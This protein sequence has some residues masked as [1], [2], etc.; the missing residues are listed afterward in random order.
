VWV[1]SLPVRTRPSLQ[2]G[3]PTSELAVSPFDHPF[4]APLVGDAEVAA[5]LAPAAEIAA[6]VAFETALAEAE[7]RSG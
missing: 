6:L 5:L 1:R 3:A 2:R 7:A 4:L